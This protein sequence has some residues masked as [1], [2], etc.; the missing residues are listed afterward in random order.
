MKAI[1]R[2]NNKMSSYT[3]SKK[4]KISK[5]DEKEYNECKMVTSRDIMNEQENRQNWRQLMS[6][7]IN[8]Q[9]CPK[10]GSYKNV[11]RLEID[12]MS[13]LNHENIITP[14]KECF[15]CSMLYKLDIINVLSDLLDNNDYENII[16][17][18]FHLREFFMKHRDDFYNNKHYC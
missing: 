4:S 14:T 17:N 15:W 11:L 10:H 12:N 2:I 3:K 7:I 18:P 16:N 6:F 8:Y 5:N 9:D 13:T 1:K